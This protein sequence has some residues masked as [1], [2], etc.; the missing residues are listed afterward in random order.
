LVDVGDGLAREEHDDFVIRLLNVIS[1]APAGIELTE[2][3]GG[4]RRRRRTEIPDA[5]GA[6]AAEEL[7]SETRAARME[8]LQGSRVFRHG[9]LAGA[10][11]KT[12]RT[13]GRCYSH[14]R[15]E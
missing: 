4:K 5:H 11:V 15:R 2:E 14:G 10:G 13:L 6:R 9:G 12:A 8:R 1:H 3:Y 7:L